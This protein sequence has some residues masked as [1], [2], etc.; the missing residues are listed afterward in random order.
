VEFVP[1]LS[2][3]ISSRILSHSFS[4]IDLP[5]LYF[6]QVLFGLEYAHA[7]DAIKEALVAEALRLSDSTS[8]FDICCADVMC[9]ALD[10]CN[11]QMS[12]NRHVGILDSLPSGCETSDTKPSTSYSIGGLTWSLPYSRRMEDNLLFWIGS[13]NPAFA[14]IVLTFNGCEIGM[15]IISSTFEI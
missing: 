6:M 13:D 7:M 1:L 11:G 12:S 8:K 9:S 4:L 14:N 3:F 15:S 10:P 2:T 5:S